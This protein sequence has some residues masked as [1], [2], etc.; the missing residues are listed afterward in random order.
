MEKETKGN[1][2]EGPIGKVLFKLAIPIM[3]SAFL[4]TAYSITDMAWIGKLGAK[5]VAGAGVGSMFVWLSQGLST[6]AR[7]GGQVHVGQKLGAGKREAAEVYGKTAVQIAIILGLLFGAV[8]IIFTDAFV[9]FFGM[10]DPVTVSYGKIYLRIVC[11]MIVFSFV[12]NTFT[13]LYTAQ[14]NSR[15]P[16]IANTIG[17]VTN[18]ILDPLLILGV[19]IF[20]RMEVMG[21]AVAT[22]TAQIIVL[23]VLVYDIIR[24]DKGK[25]ILKNVSIFS[26][27]ET[28]TAKEIVKIGGPSAIQSMTYCAISM[29]ITRLIATF[30]EGA[31][32]SQRVGGQIESLS[33]N[34]SDGF[35]AALNAFV[36]QNY[37]ARKKDR[38]Q[39]SY[40][41]AAVSIALWG[42]FIGI[43]FNV[44]PEEISRLFFYEKDIINTS[45]SYL[46]VLGISQPFMCVEILAIAGVSGLGNTKICSII[47]I[48]LTGMRIPLAYFLTGIGWGVNGIWWAFTLSS[49]VKGF[50]FHFVFKHQCK[51]KFLN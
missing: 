44:F 20:P 32:A 10:T 35:A 24:S 16:L 26:K 5:A 31:V 42:L 47:S 14:G 1:L 36:A 11:G 2:T 28:S 40:R 21:A 9:G 22:V 4:G 25:N 37:G 46:V 48:I 6:L 29:V 33:W 8:C 15:T 23:G 17:L 12:V 51:Q 30:G 19:G 27:V 45:I 18:M 3:A 41:I 43:I 13:G 38:V 50:V 34:V 39:K 49:I 7:M